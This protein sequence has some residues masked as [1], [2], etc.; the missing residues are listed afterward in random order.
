MDYDAI[1]HTVSHS[2]D[3]T[4]VPAYLMGYS[5]WLEWYS[6]VSLLLQTPHR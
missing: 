5:A 4:E 3:V 2:Q 6:R 1:I